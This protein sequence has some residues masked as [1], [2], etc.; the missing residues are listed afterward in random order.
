MFPRG[1]SIPFIP[2]FDTAVLPLGSN[3]RLNEK[4]HARPE[5]VLL[6]SD[7][8]TPFLKLLGSLNLTLYAGFA[9]TVIALF[10]IPKLEL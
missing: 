9:L 3:C 6:P 2:L 5:Y 4:P 7:T 8:L 1:I 10:V